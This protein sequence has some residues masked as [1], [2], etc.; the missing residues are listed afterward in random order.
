MNRKSTITARLAEMQSWRHA[1]NREI[2]E[3]G[4]FL[5]EHG[6]ITLATRATLAGLSAL[7]SEQRILIAF[8]AE[9]ARGKSELINALFFGDLG[10]RLLPAGDRRTTRCVTELRFDRDVRT[11]V[12]LLPIETREN[13][14]SLKELYA[15]DSAWRTVL[16]E[17]DN[18][19][20]VARALAALSETKRLTLVDAVKWGLHGSG[21]AQPVSTAGVAMVDVPRWRHAI[22]NYPHPLL[23]AGLVLLDTPGL[24]ALDAEP[25]FASTRIPQADGVIL[26]LDAREGLTKSDLAIWGRH[27]GGTRHPREREREAEGA[28]FAYKP[29]R[30]IVLNKI[31]QLKIDDELNPGREMLRQIDQKVK[32]I[33][34]TLRIDPIDVIAVS[35]L[36]GLNARFAGDKDAAVRSRM[37]QLERSIA[38]RLPDNRLE[39]RSATVTESLNQ[40]LAGAQEGLD[41]QRFATLQGLQTLAELRNK[42]EKLSTSLVSQHA[43]RAEKLDN[44]SRELRAVKAVQAKLAE[45][46]TVIVDPAAAKESIKV[47][48][49]AIVS[50][51]GGRTTKEIV[52]DFLQDT[53]LKLNALD[54]KIEEV[55]E[56]Y[57]TVGARI[58]SELRFGKFEVHPFATHRF[59]TELQKAEQKADAEFSRKTGVLERRSSARAEQFDELVAS[60]VLHVFEIANRE[61]ITWM[62]GL[63]AALEQPLE[64]AM[65]QTAER[66]GSVEKI[67]SAELDLAER[68]AELQAQVDVIKHKHD[69]LAELR[70]A[71][72]R[73]LGTDDEDEI[74]E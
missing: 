43:T 65:R 47:A 45:E 26:V 29:M 57:R 23:D 51:K 53:L 40:M 24:A 31:D 20:S 1:L 61:C 44:A 52:Q 5:Q 32:T 25:E 3:V 69:A 67:K 66:S 30:L 16:F 49:K 71:M 64:K 63:H 36:Q 28:N 42:N 9:V 19:D 58:F 7:V 35:A 39:A 50:G 55:R 68:I 4:S 6:F 74:A 54:A 37:Y 27:M 22:I 56:L 12:R 10:R 15:D 48:R 46:L 73:R 21:I 33:A 62:R 70:A 14:R 59:H 2:G 13:A 8:I 60:R 17:A 41:Q 18:A 11:G 38:A 34:D 72:A